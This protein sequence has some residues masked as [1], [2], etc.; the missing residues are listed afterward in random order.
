VIEAVIRF[1]EPYTRPSGKRK[2]VEAVRARVG[3]QADDLA[4]ARQR[5]GAERQKLEAIIANLLDNLTAD[6]RA[7]VDERLKELRERRDALSRRDEELESLELAEASI[8]ATVEEP[9][10]FLGKLA[11]TLREGL[12]Q[13]KL[14]V[15]RQCVERVW[16]DKP[17]DTAKLRLRVV[18]VGPLGAT[19]EEQFPLDIPPK[20]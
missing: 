20:Q 13:E 2:L 1:Y 6:N 18:P 8:D 12:P 9:V 16:I 19:A 4:E 11:F 5:V 10:A 7:F 15:L 17:T 3:A 14:V